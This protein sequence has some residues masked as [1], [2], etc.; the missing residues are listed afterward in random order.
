[1]NENKEQKRRSASVAKECAYAATFTALLIAAQLC[2]SALPSVEVVTVLFFS[3]AFVFG[4]RRGVIVG[5]AFSLLRMLVFGFFPS[6]LI[7]YLL[8]YPLAAA[9]FG[10]LG[11]RVKKPLVALWWLTAI[12]CLCAFGFSLLDCVIT[13]LWYRFTLGAAR[14]Y[15]LG[16]LP[17]AGGQVLCT[18]AT[19]ALLFLP[20]TRALGIAKKGLKE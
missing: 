3:Y 13:P 1:M 8:Y 6:V 17:V 14:G 5:V 7:L 18:A 12:A 10:W 16:S 15:F 9:L 11:R 2:F 4:G 20:L 19:V